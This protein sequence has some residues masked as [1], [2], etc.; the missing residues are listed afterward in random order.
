MIS[1]NKIKYKKAPLPFNGQKRY[2]LSHFIKSLEGLDPLTPIYDIFGG[3]GLLANACLE[4][5]FV[6]VTYN[7]YNGYANRIKTIK[8][9]NGILKDIDPLLCKYGKNERISVKDKEQILDIIRAYDIAEKVDCITLSSRLLFSSHYS[10]NVN[11]LAGEIFYARDAKAKSYRADNYL[12]GARITTTDYRPLIREGVEK[13]AVLILD[14]PYLSTDIKHYSK[15]E[16]WNFTEYLDLIYSM[17]GQR[18]IYFTSDKSQVVE[19][20]DWY[21]ARGIQS[22]FN[23]SR[24][25]TRSNAP[26]G[27]TK[28]TDIMYAKI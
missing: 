25:Y 15:K 19:L 12:D 26:T 23:G 13:G 20:V 10:D 21:D 4:V 14:P 22:P 3:S 6:D 24:V 11:D 17:D 9:T 18:F 2:M 7:D 27:F 28:F 5:G 16:Y 8:T 1:Y